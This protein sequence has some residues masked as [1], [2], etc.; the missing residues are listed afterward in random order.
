ML[1]HDAPVSPTA[2]DA[3]NGLGCAWMRESHI[4]WICQAPAIACL[5][6]NGVFLLMIMWVSVCVS[7]FVN[8]IDAKT[9]CTQVLI[10]KLRSANTAE[11]QQYRK[12]SK[13]LL[14]LIPL[15]G[16]TYLVVLHGPGDGTVGNHV[17]VFVRA[18]LLSTQGF[19][20]AL[21][22][23]F[24]NSEVRTTLRH[25]IERWHE[26]RNLQ[27]GRSYIQKRCEHDSINLN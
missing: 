4:D 14:V 5:V 10:T 21:L 16:I 13:A 24:L 23:C 3:Q 12:A 26:E 19:A 27:A 22:Y 25:R 1:N 15:L 6:V 7:V 8:A 11:T 20:V 18:F 17:F 2:Y 9:R